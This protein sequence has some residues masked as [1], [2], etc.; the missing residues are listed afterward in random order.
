MTSSLRT[1]HEQPFSEIES[2]NFEIFNLRINL[3][4]NIKKVYFLFNY[5]P[6]TNGATFYDDT[7]E[8]RGHGASR[9]MT[10][11]QWPFS[12]VFLRPPLGTCTT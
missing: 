12:S 5:K 4:Y 3:C 7:M 11:Q 10:F 8:E 2:V 1:A 9:H 6:Q